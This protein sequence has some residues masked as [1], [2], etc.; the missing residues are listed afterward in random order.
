MPR[1]G[2]WLVPLLPLLAVMS[3]AGFVQ[4]CGAQ[5]CL[6]GSPFY[7]Q[8]ADSY[9]LIDYVKRDPSM[10]DTFFDYCNQFGLRVIRLWAFNHKMPYA[11]PI[12]QYDEDEF[13]G[14]DF[15]VD[16]AGRKGIKLIL[17]FGGIWAAYRTP[18]DFM[19]MAGIDADGK[20]LLYFYGSPELRA[21]YK[22]HITAI[23]TRVNTYNSVRYADDPAI[24]MWDVLNEPRC[25]GCDASDQATQ[26]SFLQD[27][28]AHLKAQAP[29]QL[30][31]L[32]TEG[33]FWGDN[34]GWNPGKLAAGERGV[35]PSTGGGWVSV[36]RSV[37]R[38]PSQLAA[39]GTEGYFWGDN[40]GWNPGAATVCEG[41]D[42]T[43]INTDNT[44]L[45]VAVVPG[46]RVPLPSFALIC[47][48]GSCA[49]TLLLQ[50]VKL[51]E[52]ICSGLG[53]PLVMEEY[54]A[55]LPAFTE[56]ER[57]QLFRLTAD[58]LEASKQSGG[59]LMGVMFWN[60]AIGTV[61][62][63]GYNIYLDAPIT[64]PAPT[65]APAAAPEGGAAPAGPAGEPGRAAITPNLEGAAAWPL[66][67]RVHNE[68]GKG[69]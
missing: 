46:P 20:D 29:S 16:S 27:M 4:R 69:G 61:N 37:G 47:C 66:G 15:I 25:P 32:G 9:W 5:L 3:R 24:M 65:A 30:A 1:W 50:Y 57:V 40:E 22:L 63:D 12:P 8:G 2:A 43:K 33:Y 36:G 21:F 67:P 28:A 23:V 35:W 56:A 11:G 53:K 55:I 42:W 38:A 41:E 7:F 60:A 17:A 10:I 44:A 13:T 6:D 58:L 68:K 19:T 64:T 39:L 48:L 31:A 14:L 59:P 26:Q 45:D 52:S 18:V 49:P 51:H 62:D 54:G 34:E